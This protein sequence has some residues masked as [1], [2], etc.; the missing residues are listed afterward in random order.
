MT[1]PNAITEG[2]SALL[3]ILKQ[4]CLIISKENMV[5]HKA[6]KSILAVCDIFCLIP[7]L[8]LL[9]KDPTMVA[10]ILKR[11]IQLGYVREFTND[12]EFPCF[13]PKGFWIN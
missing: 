3:T 9:Y 4:R 13:V 5:T 6:W 2:E 8:E 1:E 12:K 11:L 10:V 7:T